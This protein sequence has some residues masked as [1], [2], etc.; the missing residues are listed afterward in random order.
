M[1]FNQQL[2]Q[3]KLPLNNRYT[4]PVKGEIFEPVVILPAVTMHWSSSFSIHPNGK[5]Q[6]VQ[7][8]VTA[9]TDISGGKLNLKIPKNW[10]VSILNKENFT[11]VE[12]RDKLIL[13]I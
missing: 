3:L 11:Q 10:N 1:K 7:L 13:L 6:K 8:Q 4:D 12:K 2:F 5:S 9:H